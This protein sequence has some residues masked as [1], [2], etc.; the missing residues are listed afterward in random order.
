MNE[1]HLKTR[2]SNEEQ[3]FIIE[4]SDPDDALRQG[5]EWAN[6]DYESIEIYTGHPT[7][8]NLE[9]MSIDSTPFKA[10]PKKIELKIAPPERPA[11]P[12][13][14]SAPPPEDSAPIPEFLSS[15]GA[16]TDAPLMEKSAPPTEDEDYPPTEDEDYQIIFGRILIFIG[17]LGIA[18]AFLIPTH[19]DGMHN[20]GLLQNREMIMMVACTLFISGSVL[21]KKR[22]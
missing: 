8:G 7:L 18:A 14:K 21:S 5:I 9:C 6:Q 2:V 13:K 4:A 1:Y 17:A 16:T 20:L 19:R 11:P 10:T 22:N 12:P 3:I 15:F